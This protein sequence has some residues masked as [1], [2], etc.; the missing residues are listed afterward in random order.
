MIARDRHTSIIV[1][2]SAPS[3]SVI[4]TAPTT[5][6]LGHREVGSSSR[7]A[8]EEPRSLRHRRIMMSRL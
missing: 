8:T 6:D 4:S 1:H 7:A 5:E 3:P 2:A